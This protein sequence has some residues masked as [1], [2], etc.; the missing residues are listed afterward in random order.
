[1]IFS[2]EQKAIFKTL[3]NLIYKEGIQNSIDKKE[4]DKRAD[5]ICKDSSKVQARC[6]AV[7]T[8]VINMITK[9]NEE[10]QNAKDSSNKEKRI[11]DQNIKNLNNT[12]DEVKVSWE[13]IRQ[14]VEAI[15]KDIKG[16]D[17]F[18]LFKIKWL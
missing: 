7:K 14:K 16:N 6:E 13:T 4:I 12:K 15:A 8:S 3:N 1:M 17:K 5:I 9:K 11:V 18:G 10:I 2:S